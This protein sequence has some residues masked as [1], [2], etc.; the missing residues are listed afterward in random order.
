MKIK[1]VLFALTLAATTCLLPAQESKP[2]PEG[3]RPLPPPP[4]GPGFHVL[5]RGAREKLNLNAEQQKQLA[6][7]ETE[8]KAKIEKIL[9]PEQL[10]QLRQMRPPQG[11]R[12][13][14][15]QGGPGGPGQ[16]G[17]PDS[18]GAPRRPEPEK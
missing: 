12:G 5:P 4:G 13:P 6:D 16:Q 3:E 11:Q 17:G 14:G 7:L 1:A 8:V 9:T 15:G 2:G 10:E 18:K